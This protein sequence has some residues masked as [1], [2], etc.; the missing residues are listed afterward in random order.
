MNSPRTTLLLVAN[1]DSNVG[2]AWWLMESYW[3]VLAEQYHPQHRILLAYPSISTVPATIQQSPLQPLVQDFGCTD[4]RSVWQQCLFLRRNGVRV[5][6]FSDRATWHWR[7]LL[8]RLCGVRLIIV[9]DHTPGERTPPR[10]LKRWLKSVVQRLPWITAD[11]LIG[12]TPYVRDRFIHIHCAP[13]DRC[14]TAPNGLPPLKAMTP[15]SVHALFNIPSDRRILVMVGR[16]NRYKGIDFVLSCLAHLKSR[17]HTVPHFL[18]C[19]DGPDLR[20][21]QQ[22]AEQ[23]GVHRH[24]TFAGRR[25][26]VPALLESCDIAIHPS[27]GEVGYSLSILEYMRAGLPVLVPDNPSVCGATRHGETGLIYERDNVDAACQALVQLLE[28]PDMCQRMGQQARQ[29]VAQHYSLASTH[30]ALLD[31]F[32]HIDHHHILSPG[33]S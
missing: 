8:Y 23:L 28:Q 7:Y 30:T 1:W 4:P 31:A 6:Y 25:N 18:F 24:V 33:R 2:Y 13:A 15:P 11:G 19:G 20:H 16:A 14:F 5:I 32:R 9:H 12:A 21:F 22:Q 29:E 17:G 10:G 26:D 3:I 27:Q